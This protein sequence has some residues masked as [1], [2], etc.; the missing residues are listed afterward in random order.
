MIPIFPLSISGLM[1]LFIAYVGVVTP[2]NPA[3]S[4]LVLGVE[5]KSRMAVTISSLFL[6]LLLFLLL[7]TEQ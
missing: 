3:I 4:I 5:Q 1:Y 7:L 6:A 2:R